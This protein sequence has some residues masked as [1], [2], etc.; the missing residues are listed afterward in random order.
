MRRRSSLARRP[1]PTRCGQPRRDLGEAW[2][3]AIVDR[4]KMDRGVDTI[5]N[6][7]VTRPIQ[8]ASNGPG[9]WGDEPGPVCSLASSELR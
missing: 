7:A 6:G 2:H 1:D 5:R 9:S 4:S 3:H 8:R